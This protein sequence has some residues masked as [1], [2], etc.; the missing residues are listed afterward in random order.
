MSRVTSQSSLST[1][2]S[3]ARWIHPTAAASTTHQGRLVS[4]LENFDLDLAKCRLE[5][6]RNLAVEATKRRQQDP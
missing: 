5:Y 4:D 6:D 1:M 3:R 2:H